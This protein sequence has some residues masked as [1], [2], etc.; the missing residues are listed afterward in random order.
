MP[1]LRQHIDHAKRLGIPERTA[2]LVNFIKGIEDRDP[3]EYSLRELTDRELEI[4][5]E[6]VK[7]IVNDPMF[8]G[9]VGLQF[10]SDE[11]EARKKEINRIV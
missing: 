10:I 2:L 8:P 1:N 7:K 3:T 4:L 6:E 9:G 11:K 5:E